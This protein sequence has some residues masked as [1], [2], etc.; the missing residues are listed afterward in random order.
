MAQVKED[1]NLIEN[2]INMLKII[3]K[4]NVSGVFPHIYVA[5]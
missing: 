2:S 4:N 3:V 5:F 1:Q